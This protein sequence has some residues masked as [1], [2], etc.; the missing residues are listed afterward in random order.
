M[1]QFIFTERD[2]QP[3]TGVRAP[4]HA[5]SIAVGDYALNSHGHGKAGALHPDVADGDFNHFTAPFQ[6]P[7]GVIVPQ[8]VD[9]LLV[10]VALSASHIGFSALR[11]EPTWTALGHAA[12]HAAHLALA[13]GIALAQVPVPELQSRLWNDGAAV[14]Y[15]SDIAPGTPRFLTVQRL[16]LR[17]FLHD[18]AEL[19]PEA[20]GVLQKRHGLQYAWP[21][22]H[23]AFHPDRPLDDALR[24]RWL[25]R[26]T[27]DERQRI[28]AGPLTRGQFLDAL[29]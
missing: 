21:F 10:P 28:P 5:D 22:P 12:G 23:H 18:I 29:R 24:A 26:L 13:K 4:L 8:K 1:G 19:Y 9:N 6:I 7:Y 2:T 20:F 27:A 11:L 14:I 25:T 16:G 3:H 17:G 15:T